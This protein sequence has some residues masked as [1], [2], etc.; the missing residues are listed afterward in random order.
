MSKALKKI[1]D[2]ANEHGY[3]ELDL[4]DRGISSVSDIP[5]LSKFR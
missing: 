1:V 5:N 4:C 2:E 3:E